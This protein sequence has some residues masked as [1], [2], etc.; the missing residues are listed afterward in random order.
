[1]PRALRR[2]LPED[3]IPNDQ[4]KLQRKD[5]KAEILPMKK[6][7]RV[8]VGPY[9]TFYFESFETMWLQ[10]QEMLYIE[11]GGADQLADE[12]HAYNPMIPQGSELCATL[13][14]EIDDPVRRDRVLHQLGHIEDKT[15]IKVGPDKIFARPEQEVERTTADG[16]T[17]AVHFLHFDFTAAQVAAFKDVSVEVLIGF[18]HEQYGHMTLVNPTTRQ[19]LQKDFG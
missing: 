7:R 17:S 13:M 11:K 4:W 5:T 15:W 9:A 19:E 18:D 14:F 12:L 6:N 16:K 2:I 8:A 3:V 1:M 10:V